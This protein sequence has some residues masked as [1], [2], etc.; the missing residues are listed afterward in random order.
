MRIVHALGWYFPDS[1]GGTEV[2][3]AALSRYLR[4]GGHEVLVAAPDA[5]SEVARSYEHDGVEVYRYPIPQRPTRAE[6]QSRSATRGTGDFHRWLERTKPDVFHCHSLVTGLGLEELRVARALGARVIATCHTPSLGFLCQRGT[7]M[8]WGRELCD[9]I[10]EPAKC[11]SCSL[12]A[13]GLPEPMARW[14]GALPQGLSEMGGRIPGRLGTAIGMKDLIRRNA[15]LQRELLDTVDAFVLLTAWALKAVA[16]NQ[17]SER[18][19]ALNRLGIEANGFARPAGQRSS[20]DPIRFGYLGRFHE[21]KGI[22]VLAEAIRSLPRSLPLS[23]ELRGPMLSDGDRVA[24]EK[25]EA[26]LGGDSRI[27]FAPAVEHEDTGRVLAGYDVLLCPSI[28]LEG[29]PTVAME[30]QAVGTPVIGSRIGGLAEIVEDG[31]NGRL[32]PP[33]DSKALESS[34]REVA[35]DPKRI[36]RWRSRLPAPRTMDEVARDYMTLYREGGA[37]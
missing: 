1:L 21:P 20:R 31:A 25:L 30:A 37:A 34:I 23:V 35:E 14:M 27:R 17:G 26:M 6:V 36:E 28:C 5:R 19:L 22:F 8:S 16:A 32:L 9:G 7:M 3:V 18:K 29:G 13:R 2:Y 15:A 12:Q 10:A 24:R 11:A 4:E 33:G